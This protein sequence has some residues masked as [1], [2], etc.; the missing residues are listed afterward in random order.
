MLI[1]AQKYCLK[2]SV[3]TD[4]DWSSFWTDK[5]LFTCEHTNALYQPNATGLFHCY[6]FKYFHDEGI[7]FSLSNDFD[8]EGRFQAYWNTLF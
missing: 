8:F 6:L 1:V 3:G 5:L 4:L 7:I 2:L